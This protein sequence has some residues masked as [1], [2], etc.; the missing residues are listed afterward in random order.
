MRPCQTRVEPLS[1]GTFCALIGRV[2]L[3]E[4]GGCV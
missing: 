4:P 2:V 1:D 3:S